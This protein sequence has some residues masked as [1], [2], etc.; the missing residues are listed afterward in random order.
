MH[1]SNPRKDEHE[2]ISVLIRRQSARVPS[3]QVKRLHALKG[4]ISYW[5]IQAINQIDRLACSLASPDRE[6]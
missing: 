4:L 6:R 3:L 5:Q 2:G 1:H